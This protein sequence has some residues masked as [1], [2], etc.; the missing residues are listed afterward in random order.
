MICKSTTLTTLTILWHLYLL[1]LSF[2]IAGSNVVLALK[3][4]VVH[5]FFYC[6]ILLFLVLSQKIRIRFTRYE[7]KKPE[8][9]LER[10][11]KS[12]IHPILKAVFGLFMI[13][14]FAHH[15]LIDWFF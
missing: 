11:K 7:I 15:V 6:W 1:A 9:H 4:I 13:V 10:L 14:I 2:I 12:D 8:S 3:I 5:D